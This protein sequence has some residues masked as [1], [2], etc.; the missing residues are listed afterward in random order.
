MMTKNK[1]KKSM[2]NMLRKLSMVPV[3]L[4]ALY[5]FACNSDGSRNSAI[6]ISQP[7]SES[8]WQESWTPMNDMEEQVIV[9]GYGSLKEDVSTPKD[10]MV[11]YDSERK[12]ARG[13][14][15]Y[16]EVEQKP[17]FQGADNNFRLYLAMNLI[18]PPVAQENGIVGTVVVSFIVDKDGNVTDVKSPVK[19]EILSDEL[20]RVIK[21]SPAWKPGS[22]GGKDVAVQCY[23]FVEFRLQGR[24]NSSSGVATQTND[25]DIVLFA[26]VDEKPMFNGMKADEGFREYIRE[27]TIYPVEAQEKGITG[28]IY[29]EFTIDKDGSVTNV[30][31][32][33]GVDPLLDAEAMRVAYSSSKKWTPGKHKGKAV[34]VRYLFPVSFQLNK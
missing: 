32:L 11:T 13:A 31:L 5:L 19:I 3:A 28:K 25:D 22:Q 34:G 2:M 4:I 27:N 33:R 7:L 14:T 21:S 23:T 29:V 8:L 6:E 17:V 12:I 24:N 20:E 9:V 15:S 16:N 26:L 18:Y 1:N 10:V 30:K